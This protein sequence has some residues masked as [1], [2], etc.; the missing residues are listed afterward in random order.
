MK[1]YISKLTKSQLNPRCQ[2]ESVE[3]IYFK[4]FKL[5]T[6]NYLCRNYNTTNFSIIKRC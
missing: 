1:N 2:S 4:T 3:D 6:K 5:K